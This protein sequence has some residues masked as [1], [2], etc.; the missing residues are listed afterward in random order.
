MG[1]VMDPS[2][3]DRQTARMRVRTRPSARS[4]AAIR[5]RLNTSRRRQC[6]H[7]PLSPR[8]RLVGRSFR[9][10]SSLEQLVPQA[11]QDLMEVDRSETHETFHRVSLGVTTTRGAGHRSMRSGTSVACHLYRTRGSTRGREATRRCRIR[12]KRRCQEP[13]RRTGRAVRSVCGRS[14][15]LRRSCLDDIV[16]CIP[17]HDHLSA[18]L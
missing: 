18:M 17:L 6:A 4:K 16:F 13:G 8:R 10:S 9:A 7:H 14:R 1:W 3:T 15:L 11:Q 12:V 5:P 2:G